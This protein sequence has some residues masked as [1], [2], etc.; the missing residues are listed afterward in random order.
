MERIEV[1]LENL[2]ESVSSFYQSGEWHYIGMNGVDEENTVEVQWIFSPYDGVRELKLLHCT[3]ERSVERTVEGT[4]EG[5]VE[6][7][8]TIP[9]LNALIP[10]A[11][12]TEGE[13][14]DMFDLKVEGAKKGFFLEA[15]SP[16]P[17]KDRQ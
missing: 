6:E 15:D 13:F 16:Q 10:S 17:L 3:V 14:V 11:W 5:T 1:T 4:V 8:P 9:S 12:A 2:Q 7:S